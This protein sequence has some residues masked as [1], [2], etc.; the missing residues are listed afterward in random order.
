MREV[1]AVTGDEPDPGT[2]APGHD[3]DAVTLD[4]MQPA[5]PG[6][7][8]WA[9]EGKQGLMTPTERAARERNITQPRPYRMAKAGDIPPQ[10]GAPIALPHV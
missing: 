9:G 8:R 4:F 3:A 7:G 10:S 5:V 2:I 6:I 1:I